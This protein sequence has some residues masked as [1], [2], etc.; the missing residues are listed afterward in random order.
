[1][2]FSRLE[3]WF[4]EVCLKHK[5]HACHW[6]NNLTIYLCDCD[7]HKSNNLRNDRVMSVEPSS[8]TTPR[9][10]PVTHWNLSN[11]SHGHEFDSIFHGKREIQRPWDDQGRCW[12]LAIARWPVTIYHCPYSPRP[13]GRLH[14]ACYL[15]RLALSVRIWYAKAHEWLWFACNCAGCAEGMSKARTGRP[16]RFESHALQCKNVTV[17]RK[18]LHNSGIRTTVIFI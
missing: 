8:D 14:W 11:I 4:L 18:R 7:C 12:T 13:G 2:R 1:M 6:I 10:M 15:L 9:L 5:S 3:N 16:V 17:G